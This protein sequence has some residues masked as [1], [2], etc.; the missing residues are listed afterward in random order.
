MKAGFGRE[1][2]TPPLGVELCGYGYY[3][4]RRAMSVRDDLYAMCV[5]FKSEK[6][7]YLII[8]CDLISFSEEIVS[9][10]RRLVKTKYDI[11]EGSVMIAATH[12]HCGPATMD[13]EG[14][15][16][17]DADYISGLPGKILNAVDKAMADFYGIEYIQT[18]A[19]EITPIGHNRAIPRGPEDHFVRGFFIKRINAPAIAVASYNCHPVSM[20]ISSDISRDYA[21]QAAD[22]LGALCETGAY[23]LFITGVCGDINP[24]NER[25]I[26]EQTKEFGERI[27]KGFYAGLNGEKERPEHF[28]HMMIKVPL[29]LQPYS[30]EKIKETSLNIQN[31]GGG[32]EHKRVVALWEERLLKKFADGKLDLEYEEGIANV[33]AVG[34]IVI[35]GINYETFTEIGSGIREALPGKTVIVAGNAEGVRGYF[36]TP[37][38]IDTGGGY[39]A[40]DSMFLY[41]KLPL[42]RDAAAVFVEKVSGNLKKL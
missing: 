34:S 15:G 40:M 2:I 32:N 41:R 13:S 26:Y 38:E 33:F 8:Y 12:T 30:I 7:V 18:S 9:E 42:S 11:P 28:S 27:A 17:P 14:C 31:G 10:I 3:L 20:G 23:G 19:K 29:P 25:G 4:Q 5:A 16:E 1:K 39:A 24:P 37:A 22:S 6:E 21:G 35:V 36:S